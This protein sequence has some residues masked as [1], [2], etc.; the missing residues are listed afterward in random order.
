MKHKHLFS[1]EHVTKSGAALFAVVSCLVLTQEVNLQNRDL[2]ALLLSHMQFMRQEPLPPQETVRLP[3]QTH[4]SFTGSVR[5]EKG[6]TLKQI[7][8][9]RRLERMQHEGQSAFEHV[10][11]SALSPR[12]HGTG[13]LVIQHSSSAPSV[14]IKA[15][16]G[17]GLLTGSEQCD[18]G[19]TVDGDGC[20]SACKIEPGFQCVTTQPS[21]CWARC[22]DGIKTTTEKCDDGNTVG[23]DGCSATCNIEFGYICS[24]SPSV[25]SIPGICGDGKVN[26]ASETCDDGNTHSGDGCSATCTVESGYT[27]TDTPS[28]CTAQ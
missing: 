27:C 8:A 28:V 25:C 17:D 6:M 1:V 4:A 14:A 11:P 19:N 24:G 5:S 12:R 21:R 9:L 7:A 15:G 16:C 23:G 18:D 26:A 10:T 3:A 20:S 2:P 22:G 13:M